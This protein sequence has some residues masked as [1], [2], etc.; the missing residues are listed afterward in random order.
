MPQSG[1]KTTQ[2]KLWVCYQR[3]VW[4]LSQDLHRF[5]HRFG[6]LLPYSFSTLVKI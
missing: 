3:V 1:L 4:Y 2:A 5:V 6:I